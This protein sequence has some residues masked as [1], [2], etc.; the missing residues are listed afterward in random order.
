M[1]APPPTSENELLARAQA[2]AGL[3]VGHLAEAQGRPVPRDLRRHKGWLGELLESVL[4]AS[5]A[6]RPEP[7]FV[8]L[9][10]ELKTIP[11]SVDGRPLES[12][13]VCTVAIHDLVGQR[14]QTSTVRTKLTRV[15]WIPIEAPS[16]VALPARRVG[17]P[18][19]WSPDAAQERV[20][21][22]DWEEHMELLATGRFD[23][24]DA[25]LG[26]YLQ[27][28]PKAA[29]GRALVS[30]SDSDGV[31]ATTLPRGFYLRPDF[32]ATILNRLD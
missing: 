30:A 5:A 3:T 29:N 32:T 6:S 24:V 18:V 15:L 17:A 19:L 26:V 16:G 8:V 20:L 2:C 11:V 27:I 4:G 31:P 7:D 10:I 13:H 25:R 1:R 21:R 14:W 23:A 28:R 12:T 9:G 22:A